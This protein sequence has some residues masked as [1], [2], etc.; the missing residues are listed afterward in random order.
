MARLMDASISMAGYSPFSARL[1][2][3]HDMA[4]QDRAGGIG[5]GVVLIVSFHQHGIERR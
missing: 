1:P 4:V 2:C 3:Q 5:N